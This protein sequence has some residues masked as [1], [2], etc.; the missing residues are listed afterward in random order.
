[1]K[2]AIITG[3]NGLIGNAV[4][5][6]LYSIGIEV[7]CLGRRNMKK[8]CITQ[9]FGQGASYLS[10]P[11]EKIDSLP[12]KMEQIGWEPENETVF[13]H[14]AWS[15]INRLTDGELRDQLKNVSF[16]SKAVQIAK[17]IGCRKF[18]NAGTIQESYLELFLKGDQKE[19]YQSTQT[20]YALAKLASRDTC[21]IVSYLKKIDYVH[22]RLSAP[23]LL[24]LSRGGY[25]ASTLKN[26]LEGKPYEEPVAKQLFDIIAVEDVAVAY[27]L[28]G[29]KGKNKHDYFIGTEKP[30][31]LSQHFMRFKKSLKKEK[32]I[33]KSELSG[34]EQASLFSTQALRQDTCFSA[35]NQVYSLIKK[36]AGK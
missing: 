5:K 14:F 34:S 33:E 22:T 31:T 15:G 26:I 35:S 29:E 30:A 7:L 23:I 17:L 28:I 25:I 36:V 8:E 32:E 12:E 27:R 18:V 4:A 20:N 13:F 11:M 3:A 16:A 24:N 2:K 19:P 10:L 9:N 1:M 6:Y 21:K